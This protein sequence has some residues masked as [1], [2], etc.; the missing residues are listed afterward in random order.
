MSENTKY[1]IIRS[2][3]DQE[4]VYE[5][6]KIWIEMLK[7]ETGSEVKFDEVLAVGCGSD[8]KVGTPTVENAS[9]TGVVLGTA[10]QKKIIIFKHKRR[11]NHRNKTGHRQELMQIEIKSIN[12]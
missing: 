5:G 11:K 6:D 4:R 12:A 2:G 9:V 1:A 10:K 8:I 3:S 7:A